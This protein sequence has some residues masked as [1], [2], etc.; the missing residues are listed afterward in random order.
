[1][2]VSFNNFAKKL[3]MNNTF[4]I[5]ILFLAAI[6]VYACSSGDDSNDAQQDNF[7]RGAMLGELG[8]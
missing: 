6:V 2:L 4:K 1:M 8:G 5:L 3:K 7:D